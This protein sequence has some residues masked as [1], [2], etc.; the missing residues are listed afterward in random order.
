M[1]QQLWLT[2]MI[3]SSIPF[4]W[5]MINNRNDVDRWSP[6]IRRIINCPT[7][8]GSSISN[9]V[10]ITILCRMLSPVNEDSND[11]QSNFECLCSPEQWS[12]HP[13]DARRRS[14]RLGYTQLARC[15]HFDLIVDDCKL[16]FFWTTC[17][18]PHPPPSRINQ[19]SWK[20][21]NHRMTSSMSRSNSKRCYRE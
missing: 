10:N 8:S 16:S 12:L 20:V 11:F 13:S 19:E 18:F 21:I 6:R 3:W 7:L 5:T 4:H 17:T 9:I 14:I 15:F 1:N 2:S